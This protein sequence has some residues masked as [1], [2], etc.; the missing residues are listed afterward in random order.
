MRLQVKA[1]HGHITDSVRRYAETKLG[2]LGKRMHELTVVE[3]TLARDHNP[4]I[5]DDH[6]AEAVVRA[7]GSTIVVR[8]RAPSWEVAV[9]R[10]VDK[11]ERQVE[12]YRDKRTHEQRRRVPQPVEAAPA[13]EPSEPPEESAA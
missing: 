13:S 4:S 12:R 8:E 2:K 7:K 9:D 6:E 11:L 1:R 3:L 5:A 10:L